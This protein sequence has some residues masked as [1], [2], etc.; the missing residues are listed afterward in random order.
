[1]ELIAKISMSVNDTIDIQKAY[2]SSNMNIDFFYKSLDKYISKVE[3][4]G[5]LVFVN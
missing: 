1:M 2:T 3:P 4:M 5:L